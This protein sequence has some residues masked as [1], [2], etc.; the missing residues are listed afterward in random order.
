MES[1]VQLEKRRAGQAWSRCL[2]RWTRLHHLNYEFDFAWWLRGDI[3]FWICFQRCGL[4]LLVTFPRRLINHWFG[5]FVLLVLCQLFNFCIFCVVVANI[6][7]LLRTSDRWLGYK[8]QRP[9]HLELPISQFQ[10]ER[11]LLHRTWKVPLFQQDT[12]WWLF[13]KVPIYFQ[14]ISFRFSNSS[15]QIHDPYTNLRHAYL[16]IHRHFP[17][18]WALWPWSWV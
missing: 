6:L 15:I 12:S 16:S 14:L 10:R 11:F 1:K 4:L 8:W 5:Y 3:H 18:L 2:H 17:V 9:C 7:V 13:W